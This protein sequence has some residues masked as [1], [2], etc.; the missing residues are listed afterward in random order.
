MRATKRML[1]DVVGLSRKQAVMFHK[2]HGV[3]FESEESDIRTKAGKVRSKHLGT[4]KNNSK[5]KK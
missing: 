5:K 4:Q 2:E 1:Q 3:D